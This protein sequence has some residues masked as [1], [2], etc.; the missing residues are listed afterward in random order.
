MQFLMVFLQEK[1]FHG[2]ILG[3]MLKSVT[4]SSTRTGQ[5]FVL[6]H[7]KQVMYRNLDIT[8]W[9]FGYHPKYQPEIPLASPGALARDLI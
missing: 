2:R 6:K 5:P 1:L 3:A 4:M 8:T 7:W 9:D